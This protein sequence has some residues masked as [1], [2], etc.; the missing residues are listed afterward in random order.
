M[1]TL[2][3]CIVAASAATGA[4][5]ATQGTPDDDTFEPND[6]FST[7]TPIEPG[8][9]EGLNV[10]TFDQDVYAVE[11]DAGESVSASI[12][13]AH[14]QGDLELYL[15]G[16]NRTVVAASES[17]TNDESVSAVAQ[18]AGTYYLVVR[19]FQTATNTYDLTVRTG[20]GADG[21]AGTATG[22]PTGT[23]TGTQTG[24]PAGTPTGTPPGTPAGTP[25]D[26]P[27]AADRFEPND[28]IVNATRVDPGTYEGLAIAP[29][30]LDVF[31]AELAQ[32]ETLSASIN[33]SHQ[34]G[35]LDLLVV[36][37]DGSIVAVSDTETDDESLTYTANA[38]ATY[39]LV[40][41]G[42][43]NATGP[44]DLTVSTTD[45]GTATGTPG[46]TAT[47]TPGGTATGT[48]TS[49]WTDARNATETSG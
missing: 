30:D 7:A 37:G 22:T 42:Y 39:Y 5:A 32:G 16:P 45:A 21:G 46:G 6:D 3:V 15:V 19:G 14:G 17:E 11:L 2:L 18:Q 4:A 44:Y 13:F 25:T 27:T 40:V 35:D 10:S 24:T 28:N 20:A 1:A 33:F 8:T 34:R 48:S 38:S 47:E 26:A 9:Y 29:N 49:T 43:Q 23:A 41:Y 12:N 31:A 36:T